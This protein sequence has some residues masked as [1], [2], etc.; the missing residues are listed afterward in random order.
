MKRNRLL[1]LVLGTAMI[2]GSVGCAPLSRPMTQREQA[3]GIG[4]LAGGT[5]GAVIGSFAGSAVAGVCSGCP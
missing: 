4:A 3:A 5:G 1:G 2:A